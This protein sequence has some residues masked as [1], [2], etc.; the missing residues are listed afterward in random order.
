M[1][2]VPVLTIAGS[3]SCGGAGI[4]ADLKTITVLGGYGM[5]AITALTAQNTTGVRKI[6]PV[7]GEFLQEQIAAVCDDIPPASVKIGM[8]YDVPQIR[9]IAEMLQKYRPPHVVLDPVMISTSGAPLLKRSAQQALQQLLFPLAEVITPNLPEA[10]A[11]TGMTLSTSEQ[12]LSA[13]KKLSQQYH[14][15]FLLKGGHRQD[16]CEDILTDGKRC[17]QISEQ[18]INTS[19]THGTGC[20]LSSAIA[21][22]LA[23]GF[24]LYDSVCQAKQ[25]ITG[26]LQTNFSL[27]HGNGPLAHNYLYIRQER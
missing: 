10:E 16:S 8:V 26:A 3:D 17:L 18:H 27:G 1:T 12:I 7:P 23:Q 9:V 20:T 14:T 5:S 11:L 24:S 22:F 25:Y 2:A 4:Q 13:A 19:N 6:H 21:T 15:A